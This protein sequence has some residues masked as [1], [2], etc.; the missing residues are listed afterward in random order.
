MRPRHRTAKKGKVLL[1]FAQR[2]G[3]VRKVKR[4]QRHGQRGEQRANLKQELARAKVLEGIE[5]V[6]WKS[7]M[8]HVLGR[9]V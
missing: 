1:D 4:F 2:K 3:W 6:D 9:A 5:V 7:Q 8:L